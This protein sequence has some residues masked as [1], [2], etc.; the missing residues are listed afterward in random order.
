MCWWVLGEC[1][2]WNSCEGCLQD[3]SKS[4]QPRTAVQGTKIN[5]IDPF[6]RWLVT[7]AFVYFDFQFDVIAINALNFGTLPGDQGNAWGSD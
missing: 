1:A 4:L 6:V 3:G 7:G 5:P 2:Y